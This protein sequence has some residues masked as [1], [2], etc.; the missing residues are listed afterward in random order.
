MGDF[1]LLEYLT[2]E[3]HH[4]IVEVPSMQLIPVTSEVLNEKMLVKS[5]SSESV[6]INQTC[7]VSLSSSTNHS[8]LK[9]SHDK[10]F[11]FGRS[12]HV[13]T[14]ELI[15]SSSA[16]FDLHLELRT[17]YIE[18]I[19]LDDCE[20]PS[21]SVASCECKLTK[22]LEELHCGC[23]DCCHSWD[24]HE[25]RVKASKC[26][27]KTL[28]GTAELPMTSFGCGFR[29]QYTDLQSELEAKIVLTAG[30]TRKYLY[31]HNGKKRAKTPFIVIKG[32]QL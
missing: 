13:I 26:L 30:Q 16:K 14:F 25:E 22:N 3:T 2:P 31:A 4:P 18:R 21:R 23:S 12:K 6:D 10:I 32:L 27:H 28:K 8:I 20:I 9:I 17:A 29:H 11:S 7:E 15:A 1:Y 24:A 5:T 19:N